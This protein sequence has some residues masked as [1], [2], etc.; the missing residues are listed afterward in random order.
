M[1]DTTLKKF[2]EKIFGVGWYKRE[3]HDKPFLGLQVVV[4]G[5]LMG[6]WLVPIDFRIYVQKDACS[7]IPMK[8]ETKLQQARSMLKSLKLPHEFEI[9]VMFDSWY[10]NE[11]VTSI[12]EQKG[13]HWF[14]RSAT[15]RSVLWDGEEKYQQLSKYFDD[16]EI[17][18]QELH[19]PS[20]RKNPA[21]VGHQR[22]GRLRNVGRVKFVISSLDLKG[23]VRRAFFA[24]NHP[25]IPMINVLLK[26]EK[27][28]KIEVF[29]LKRPE[30][31]LVLSVGNIMT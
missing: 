30:N 26:Y 5:V 22:M 11:Q 4:L 2:G 6:D 8:F 1:D 19:Y 28:W 3:K 25:H 27:R 9:D 7:C 12:C 14:A 13:F 29:F 31:G 21:A 16:R 17:S 20:T 15:N 24:T 18:W 23:E 10:L